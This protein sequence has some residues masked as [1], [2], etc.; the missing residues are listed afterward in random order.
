MKNCFSLNH[1]HV[2]EHVRKISPHH[3]SLYAPCWFCSHLGWKSSRKLSRD[4]IT[5]LMRRFPG[6]HIRLVC[7]NHYICLYYTFTPDYCD[8]R[9]SVTLEFNSLCNHVRYINLA[10]RLS[11]DVNC[12]NLMLLLWCRAQFSFLVTS[13]QTATRQLLLRNVGH[14]GQNPKCYS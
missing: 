11:L 14:G 5:D 3:P 9:C 13:F 10:I 6:G 7:L 8:M 1:L 2:L 12:C 4:G